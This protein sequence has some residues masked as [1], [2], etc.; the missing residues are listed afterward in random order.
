[1]EPGERE[2][3]AKRIIMIV[4]DDEMIRLLVRTTFQKANYEVLTAVDGIQAM[5]LLEQN[6][7]DVIISDILMP[8]MGGIELCRTIRADSRYRMIPFMFLSIKDTLPEKIRGIEAGADG[9]IPKPF[10]PKELIVRVEMLLRTVRRFTQPKTPALSA[11][12]LPPPEVITIPEE[13]TFAQ[14]MELFRKELFAEAFYVWDNLLKKQVSDKDLRLWRDQAEG[15]FMEMVT[16]TLGSEDVIL[17]RITQNP[18]E[19]IGLAKSQEEFYLWS[20]IDGK[21]AARQLI[22]LIPNK[23]KVEIYDTLLRFLNNGLLTIK[24]KR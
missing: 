2:D 14:G 4:D 22:R 5:A 1:M 18:N 8:G 13:G 21:T 3:N 17:T 9:Y 19:I 24:K 11:N 10:N 16:S 7:P 15:K 20:S 12:G 6:L 23:H